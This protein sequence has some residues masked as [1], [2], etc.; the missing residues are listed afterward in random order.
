MYSHELVLC[1][2]PVLAGG[3][4]TSETVGSE[5]SVAGSINSKKTPT[6]H[7]DVCIHVQVH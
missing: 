2:V 6:E 1:P 5:N 7:D 3:D 4:G